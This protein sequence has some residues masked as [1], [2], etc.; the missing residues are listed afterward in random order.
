M[1]CAAEG[2]GRRRSSGSMRTEPPERLPHEGV[3]A[4][5]LR[6][7]LDRRQRLLGPGRYASADVDA[8]RLRGDRDL[9]AGGRRSG[10]GALAPAERAPTAA[11]VG[12]VGRC[13]S[14]PP[15]RSVGPAVGPCA[16][17][18]TAATR[19]G[20]LGRA[21]TFRVPRAWCR[22]WAAGPIRPRPA[23]RCAAAVAKRDA[24]YQRGFPLAYRGDGALVH[25]SHAI[26]ASIP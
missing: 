11:P 16:G 26:P 12:R 5:A 20:A 18:S 7:D 13:A 19:G 4:V 25:R 10:P 9:L 8:G 14:G 23:P 24:A 3:S 2:T 1:R 15:S 21:S 22:R 6:E 17:G